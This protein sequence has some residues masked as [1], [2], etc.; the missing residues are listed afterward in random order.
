MINNDK[1][2]PIWLSKSC[3]SY[4]II[5]LC[6]A[7]IT[8]TP[9]AFAQQ[10]QSEFSQDFPGSN[11][12]QGF[13]E[14][15]GDQD[16]VTDENITN[17]TSRTRSRREADFSPFIEVTQVAFTEFTDGS[18]DVLTYSSLAVGAD[19]SIQSRRAQGQINVRYERLFGYDSGFQDQDFV[20]GIA[21]GNYRVNRE[22][23]IEAGGVGTRSGLDSRGPTSFNQLGNQ[24]NIS[25]VYSAYAG[26]TVISNINGVDF[27]AQY[28]V[29]YSRVENGSTGPLTGGGAPIDFFS[30]SFSQTANISLGQEAGRALPIGWSL[31][32][33]F[34]QEDGNQLDQRFSDI[35]VRGDVTIPLS[36]SFFAVGGIGYED[37]Q[38]SER[39]AL[40]DAAGNP[41]ADADGRLITDEGSPRLVT[42]AED[43]IIW[44]AGVLWRP[45]RRTSVEARYGRRFG[46]ETFTGSVSYQPSDK[47]SFNVSVFDR[48]S[49]FGSLLNDNL[50]SIETEFN[51]F[52][53][54]LSGDIGGCAFS[55]NGG[56]CFNGA[57]Q[58][59][60]S[61]NF[62][63]RG[64]TATLSTRLGGW[65][66]GIGGGYSR[67]LF[68]AS[69]LGAQAL[70][71]DTVD[72]NYFATA[73]FGRSIGNSSNIETNIFY[74][75]N[76]SG[77][78]GAGNV[79]TY[80]FNAAYFR[81]IA[82]GLSAT[83]TVGVDVIDQD[84]F[85]DSVSASA[86]LGL[87]YNF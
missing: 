74:N 62:R 18:S 55:R 12:S 73:F 66:A 16:I 77:I 76:D 9:T 7:A 41:I 24:D 13:S 71:N 48:V 19:A 10:L 52:R 60:A 20:N 86:L 63:N 47:T 45:S 31:S 42:L 59:A 6:G 8:A 46:S 70:L 15:N 75:L 79:S 53:N 1:I 54:P 27:N 35:F 14:S 37:I 22:L 11:N 28:L 43:G 44:D 25:Q 61:S 81:R 68:F 64:V 67:R 72:Q 58:T 17:V 33:G 82:S 83:A 85:D 38:V 29:G 49:G 21:R 2:S 65:N 39:D 50:Q 3:K 4:K 34:S 57:L 23:S 5:L 87:R 26:P 84:D 69:D 40:R 32:A 78:A 30:D 56:S 36:S 51:S 80:G